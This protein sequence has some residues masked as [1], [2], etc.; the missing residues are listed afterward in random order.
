MRRPAGKRKGQSPGVASVYRALTKHAKKQAYPEAV[1]AAHT[2]FATLQ[3]DNP[4]P[5]SYSL[6]HATWR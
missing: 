1:G 6:L 5:S 3:Q 2:G 4:A